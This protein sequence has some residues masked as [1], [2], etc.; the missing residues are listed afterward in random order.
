MDCM[1]GDVLDVLMGIV[2][3]VGVIMGFVRSVKG[4]LW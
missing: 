2:G 4:D 3:V 1:K